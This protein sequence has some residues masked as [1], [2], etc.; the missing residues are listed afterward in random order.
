MKTALVEICTSGED[1]LLEFTADSG[2]TFS[3]MIDRQEMIDLYSCIEA[4][5]QPKNSEIN[6]ALERRQQEG[7]DVTLRE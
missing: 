7:F 1:F 5:L 2:V 3:P 4:Q 6:E